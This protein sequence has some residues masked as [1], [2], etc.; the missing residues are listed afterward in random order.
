MPKPTIPNT[1]RG[2][3]AAGYVY[4]GTGKC[5]G[6]GEEIAWYRTPTGG[7]IPLE[8]GTLEPHPTTCR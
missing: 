4:E 5:R 7:R 3:E 8:E 1:E 6:C 2:L